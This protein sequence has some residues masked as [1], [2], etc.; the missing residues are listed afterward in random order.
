[1]VVS[2]RNRTS[3]LLHS[4]PFPLRNL[5]L[6]PIVTGLTLK[7]YESFPSASP[8]ATHVRLPV[9]P[10]APRGY[11]GHQ[12]SNLCQANQIK[13]SSVRMRN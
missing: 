9:I 1:M 7:R 2:P 4:Q 5:R 8:Y 10:R 12:R 3:P 6:L 13:I 11:F